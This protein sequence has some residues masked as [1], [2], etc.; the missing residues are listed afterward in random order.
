[1]NK[2]L[3]TNTIESV[4]KGTLQSKSDSPS[5]P[6]DHGE[7]SINN[8]VCTAFILPP[9]KKNKYWL[10][11][12]P[13]VR[14]IPCTKYVPKNF[15]AVV[16]KIHSILGSA[17]TL[18]FRN[19]C[20]VIVGAKSRLHG[21]S[22][23]QRMRM[24]IEHLEHIVVDDNG[25][26]GKCRLWSHTT[27]LGFRVTNIV[28]H[29]AA[30]GKKVDLAALVAASG[31]TVIWRPDQFTGA[32][33]KV[34]FQSSVTGERIAVR[35]TYFDTCKVLV[36]GAKNVT[37]C[38]RAI[39][40]AVQT[41]KPFINHEEALPPKGKRFKMRIEQSLHKNKTTATKQVQAGNEEDVPFLNVRSTALQNGDNRSVLQKSNTQSLF[42]RACM[43]GNA[44]IVR[45]MLNTKGAQVLEETN[46]NGETALE[47]L[48]PKSEQT[49]YQEIFAMLVN[50]YEKIYAS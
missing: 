3:L 2:R 37:D 1:M 16:V 35:V 25:N 34:Y 12:E 6:S 10:S 49:K 26:I 13:I 40:V 14:N 32:K 43:E 36:A 31:G 33:G 44:S 15:A 29:A 11:L 45:H 27:F 19:G 48:T 18:M 8:V 39:Y 17:T 20:M 4:E 5:L 38:K 41:V 21:Q 22:I 7:I 30:H 28:A 9:F 23:L 46:E 42:I 47:L 50:C 24:M